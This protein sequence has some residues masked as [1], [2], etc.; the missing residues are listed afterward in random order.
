MPDMKVDYNILFF[1]D[2][3]TKETEINQ[4]IMD[5]MDKFTVSQIIKDY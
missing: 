3:F 5:N 1:Y 4:S 2:E